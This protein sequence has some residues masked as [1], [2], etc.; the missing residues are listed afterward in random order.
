[1]CQYSSS[2]MFR[3]VYGLIAIRFIDKLKTISQLK[4]FIEFFCWRLIEL[5]VQTLQVLALTLDVSF[6]NSLVQGQLYST[7]LV[8][9]TL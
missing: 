4:Y 3:V 1:M 2:T 8:P 7:K 6:C 5:N 9:P